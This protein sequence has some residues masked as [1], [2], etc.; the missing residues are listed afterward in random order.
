MILKGKLQDGPRMFGFVEKYEYT[1]YGDNRNL[2]LVTTMTRSGELGVPHL[3]FGG[4]FVNLYEAADTL[5]SDGLKRYVNAKKPIH[6]ILDA[7]SDIVS[8]RVRSTPK[9]VSHTVK[10][11]KPNPRASTVESIKTL[12]IPTT[13]DRQAQGTRI[14]DLL[15]DT[16]CSRYAYLEARRSLV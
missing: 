4:A 16:D 2:K 9:G 3:Y 8:L 1:T 12:E 15:L 13:P 14:L 7:N 10:I 5:G 11:L 6:S